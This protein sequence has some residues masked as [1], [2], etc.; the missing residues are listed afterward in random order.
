MMQILMPIAGSAR[1]FAEV[2]QPFPKP[3]IEVLG[4][5]MVAY[6]I[7]SSRPAEPHRFLFVVNAQD[8]ARFRLDSVLRQLTPGCI[9]VQTE[10]E[11]AGALCTALLAIDHLDDDQP[12]L[13]CNGDQWLSCGVTGAIAD[14]RARDLDVGIITFT[15][16]HPRWSFV[17]LDDEG[18]VCETAEKDVISDLAT[19]GVYYYRKA[20][21][22]VRAASQAILKNTR[23]RGSFFTVPSINQLILEGYRVGHHH[24]PISAF[25]PLGIP[26]DVQHFLSQ[27]ST[28][29]LEP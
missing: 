27:F 1:P 25:H 8:R 3:L 17:R 26:E 13:L 19:V 22:F 6:A 21:L 16:V 11:T 4:Y 23:V 28:S 9:V 24:I 5:P 12:L 2:G 29:P 20:N 7:Q 10:Q 18:L 15:A 14:F